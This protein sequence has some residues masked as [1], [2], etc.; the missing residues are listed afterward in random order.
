MLVGLPQVMQDIPD[1]R[2]GIKIDLRVVDLIYDHYCSI[3]RT[4]TDAMVLAYLDYL[5]DAITDYYHACEGVEGYDDVPYDSIDDCYR[6]AARHI[7]IA[8]EGVEE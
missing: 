3:D 1:I 4:D 8:K 2:D 6:D 5:K 7:H